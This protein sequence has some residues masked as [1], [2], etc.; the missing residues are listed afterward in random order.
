M[1]LSKNTK[2]KYQIISKILRKVQCFMI[3]YAVFSIPASTCEAISI[4]VCYICQHGG[5]DRMELMKFA[6]KITA[7]KDSDE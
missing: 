6:D 1:F 4:F 3:S 7:E 2:I 5:K